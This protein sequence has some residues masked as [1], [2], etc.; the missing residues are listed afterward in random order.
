M[1]K[2]RGILLNK[3]RVIVVTLG[4]KLQIYKRWSEEVTP[5]VTRPKMK[6]NITL[7]LVRCLLIISIA[8]FLTTG[9]IAA[10]TKTA[11]KPKGIFRTK[12]VIVGLSSLVDAF[13]KQ[14]KGDKIEDKLVRSHVVVMGAIAVKFDEPFSLDKMMKSWPEG[15]KANLRTWLLTVIQSPPQEAAS[16][17]LTKEY[18]KAIGY[19]GEQSL[20]FI[21]KDS[22]RAEIILQNSLKHIHGIATIDS[23]LDSQFKDAIEKVF[24]SNRRMVFEKIKIDPEQEALENFS[25]HLQSPEST[26]VIN[27]DEKDISKKKKELGLAIKEYAAHPDQKHLDE[28]KIKWLYFLKGNATLDLMSNSLFIII[29]VG[30]TILVLVIVVYFVWKKKQID[31]ESKNKV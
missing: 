7:C 22:L 10:T 27:P 20:F 26:A 17:G 21:G 30:G 23:K 1:Y 15:E 19:D 6:R 28:V 14:F 24:G 12:I 29:C 13:N 5:L 2:R 18:N 9:V 25:L 11:D 8:L 4:L 3:G 16:F 31:K